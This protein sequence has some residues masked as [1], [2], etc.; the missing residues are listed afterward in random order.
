MD[1]GYLPERGL[2]ERF[3]RREENLIPFPGSNYQ[4]FRLWKGTDLYWVDDWPDVDQ[5]F[6]E[7]CEK[8]NFTTSGNP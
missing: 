7:G 2:D 6:W 4:D 5:T 3:C 8:L 1:T